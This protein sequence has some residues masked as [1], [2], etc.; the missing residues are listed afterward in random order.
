MKGEGK[1]GY[2]KG[3]REGRVHEGGKGREREHLLGD[4]EMMLLNKG[5]EEGMMMPKGVEN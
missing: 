2:I 1:E 3:V 4:N 5:I